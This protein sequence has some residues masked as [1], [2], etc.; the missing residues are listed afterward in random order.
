MQKVVGISARAV[1]G[2]AED[3]A[4]KELGRVRRAA[5]V[6]AV[7]VRP[8][9][10]CHNGHECVDICQYVG[11]SEVRDGP[12]EGV[13]AERAWQQQQR[14]RE[15]EE[16]R[17]KHRGEDTREELVRWEKPTHVLP[18][19]EHQLGDSQSGIWVEPLGQ[20][21]LPLPPLGNL[22]LL[23][24]VGRVVDPLPDA[25]HHGHETQLE[26]ARHFR[27]AYEAKVPLYEVGVADLSELV[28]VQHVVLEVPSLRQHPIE[29]IPHSAEWPTQR[30]SR[31]V[32][33]RLCIV[34]VVP[35]MHCVVRYHCP[36]AVN[37]GGERRGRDWVERQRQGRH[38]DDTTPATPSF[39]LPKV[40]EIRITLLIAQPAPEVSHLGSEGIEVEV[41]NPSL[42]DQR[43]GRRS[44]CGDHHACW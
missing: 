24:R 27:L 7:E 28:M 33:P 8:R 2:R 29:P 40:C 35:P 9:V 16:T 30:K 44:E 20:R 39:D 42:V 37:P 3:L 18:R 1:I 43:G 31:A 15:E 19:L 5:L 10:I 41:I 21:L 34:L 4:E 12:A 13:A 25:G 22:E 17:E 11:E 38:A 14:R 36:A 32:V 23:V 6:K 26:C